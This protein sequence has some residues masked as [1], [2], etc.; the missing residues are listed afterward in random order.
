MN[1]NKKILIICIFILI[2][3][4]GVIGYFVYGNTMID[5]E[6]EKSIN[7]HL[8]VDKSN[9]ITILAKEQ[10]EDYVGIFYTDP[11]DANDNVTHFAYVKKHKFYSNR[12]KVSGGGKD[13]TGQIQSSTAFEDGDLNPIIFIYGNGKA[14]ELYSVFEMDAHTFMPVN[15]LEEITIPD[16][17]FVIAKDYQLSDKDN[18]VMV[19]EGSVTADDIISTMGL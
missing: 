6:S 11:I 16:K 3:A 12:Y 8:A 14:N 4:A 18:Q 15:K 5:V 1:V 7:S 10:H 17:N 2:I 9:P 13:N 19:F